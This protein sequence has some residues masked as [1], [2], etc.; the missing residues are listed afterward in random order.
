MISESV[1]SASIH[2]FMVDVLSLNDQ[3]APSRVFVPQVLVSVA[4]IDNLQLLR[5]IRQSDNHWAI[6]Q[7]NAEHPDL[8]GM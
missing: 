4:E 8:E 6:D 7:I 1:K 2:Q 3:L 5:C